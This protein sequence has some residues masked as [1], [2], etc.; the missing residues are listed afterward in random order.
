MNSSVK[1]P[2]ISLSELHSTDFLSHQILAPSFN[3]LHTNVLLTYS[4]SESQIMHMEIREKI[5][6]QC[7]QSKPSGTQKLPFASQLTNVTWVSTHSVNLGSC[8]SVK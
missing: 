2:I 7:I 6:N 3:G 4:V 1:E 8:D 5:T